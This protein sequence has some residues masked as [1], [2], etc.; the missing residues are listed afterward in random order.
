MRY[1]QLATVKRALE[2]W[3]LLINKQMLNLIVVHTKEQIIA[4]C[5]ILQQN[6]MKPTNTD[7]IDRSLKP[8]NRR[9]NCQLINFLHVSKKKI[10]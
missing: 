3:N 4:K 1:P 6:Y 8:D 5:N 9:N 7:E 2:A 10:P